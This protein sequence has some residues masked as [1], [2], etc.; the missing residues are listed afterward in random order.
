MLC[1]I[2]CKRNLVQIRDS[3]SIIVKKMLQIDVQVCLQKHL[4]SL[5]K[6]LT[7]VYRV[8]RVV[9]AAAVKERKRLNCKVSLR[10]LPPSLSSSSNERHPSPTHH[11]ALSGAWPVRYSYASTVDYKGETGYSY[12][13]EPQ[14]AGLETTFSGYLV[15][16]KAAHVPLWA[17]LLKWDFSEELSRSGSS[18]NIGEREEQDGYLSAVIKSNRQSNL[19]VVFKG[20]LVKWRPTQRQPWRATRARG[21]K[22]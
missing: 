8:I 11:T 6:S 16:W 9:L 20:V 13:H 21:G 5:V 1:R 22:G 15:G 4:K 3:F 18:T 12:P 14:L 17:F 19:E 7:V 10:F 2:V